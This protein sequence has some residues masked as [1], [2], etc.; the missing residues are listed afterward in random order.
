LQTVKSLLY[1]FHESNQNDRSPRSS[2]L[3]TSTRAK[4]SKTK[5][6]PLSAFYQGAIVL[7]D[8]TALSRNSSTP[9]SQWDQRLTVEDCTIRNLP[10][11]Y[12]GAA[13]VFGGYVANATI[14]HNL[15]ANSSWNAIAL[16]WG[17][18]VTNGFRESFPVVS[19]LIDLPRLT[20]DRTQ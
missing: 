10:V 18:C 5:L 8:I 2:R 11:E 4:D 6:L 1:F 9:V 13:A 7:G 12:S 17:W 3:G 14:Q 16:G 19:L 20:P 15:I